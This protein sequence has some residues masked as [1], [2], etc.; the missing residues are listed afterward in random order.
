VPGDLLQLVVGIALATAHT[1]DADE[2]HRLLGLVLDTI[3]DP[4]D[5][6]AVV[7]Q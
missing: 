1:D 7:D 6:S 3:P 4:A 5:R 2:P